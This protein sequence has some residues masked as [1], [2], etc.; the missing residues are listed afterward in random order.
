MPDKINTNSPDIEALS[1][2]M[3][4]EY[5]GNPE[6]LLDKAGCDASCKST[7]HHY[8]LVRDVIQQEYQPALPVDFAARVSREVAREDNLSVP[9]QK[10]VS[11]DSKR[12]ATRKSWFTGLGQP[13]MGLGMAASVAAAGFVAWQ[14]IGTQN[15]PDTESISVARL[16][17]P[18]VVQTAE[19]A[20]DGLVPAVYVREAGTRWTATTADARNHQVEQ[21]L[22]SLLMNHLE[23]STMGQ[24]QGMLAHSRVVA[25]DSVPSNESF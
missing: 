24:V 9:V 10:V 15:Q 5:Q 11:L 17:A 2:L 13:L 4:G 14:L 12:S 6:S 23:D 3:D 7:W 8:H 21:R 19:P 18:A 20:T 16:D 1:E 22:N 25:Y